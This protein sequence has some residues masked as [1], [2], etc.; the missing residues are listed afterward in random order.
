[1]MMSVSFELR[2]VRI[3]VIVLFIVLGLSSLPNAFQSDGFR[4]NEARGPID[5]GLTDPALVGAID[6]H[7]HLAP[8]SPGAGNNVR[9]LDPFEMAKLGR[10]RGMRGFVWKTQHDHTSAGVA[11]LTRKYAVPDM[12]VF[13]CIALNLSTGGINTAA[14]ERFTQI[15]GGWGRIVMMPTVDTDRERERSLDAESLLLRRPWAAL[16]PPEASRFVSVARNGELLPEVK[17]LIEVMAT[18]KTVDSNGSLVLATGHASPEEHVLLA[19]EGR[20]KGLQVVL[21]HGSNV[22]FEQQ[23][24]AVEL[25]AFLEFT[26][27]GV[28]RRGTEAARE[29]VETI[30]RIGAES[31]I[32]SSD[33]GQMRNPF[34]TDCL[35]LTAKALRE[36]GMTER[37]LD[38]MFKEN[39]A[40]LLG[41]SPW[42]SSE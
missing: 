16:L 37:E 17:H 34:P 4:I 18:L 28:V 36:Q 2:I 30:R 21:T 35:A 24:E 1:M 9:F 33:C 27:G 13:G 42:N 32:I 40:R 22:P 3:L 23:Q 38:L 31:F 20:E 10:A 14:V 26:I 25:G 8:D 11:Y 41:L 7:T 39:P 19:R 15:K 29:A 5:L 12:E 6:I